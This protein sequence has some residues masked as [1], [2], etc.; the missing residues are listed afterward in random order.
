VSFDFIDDS[1]GLFIITSSR[2]KYK[3]MLPDF[4]FNNLL[5]ENEK[6]NAAALRV[7]FSLEETFDVEY[8]IP[9]I[10]GVDL[11]CF[12]TGSKEGVVFTWRDQHQLKNNSGCF[13]RGHASKI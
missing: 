13:L 2:K 7:R 11:K 3:M 1:K 4:K 12:F 9:A 6:I 5:H 10:I 8:L